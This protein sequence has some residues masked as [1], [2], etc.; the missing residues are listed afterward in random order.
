MSEQDTIG[1]DPIDEIFDEAENGTAENG[2][3]D[4]D[5]REE[6]GGE[7]GEETSE[8]QRVTVAVPEELADRLRNAVYWTA[9]DITMS[10]LATEGIRAAVKHIEEQRNDGDP[11]PSRER[12]LKGGRPVK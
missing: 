11:F 8:K 5:D 12:E 7:N 6:K 10:D 3:A 4:P 2:D 9:A 1:S